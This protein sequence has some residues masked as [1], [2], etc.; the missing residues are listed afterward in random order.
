MHVKAVILGITLLLAACQ[1]NGDVAIRQQLDQC[2][3]VEVF[4]RC[5]QLAPAGP[6]S[7]KYNDWSEVISECEGVARRASY[8]D[9]AFVRPECFSNNAPAKPEAAP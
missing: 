8:R 2:R 5:L 3:R 4:E 6:Q 7:T 1:P 9:P